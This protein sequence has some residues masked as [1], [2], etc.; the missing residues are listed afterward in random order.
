ML[1]D[2]IISYIPDFV[3][4]FFE[5]Y[6]YN[7]RISKNKELRVA[8]PPFVRFCFISCYISIFCAL[9]LESA[10]WSGGSW[11]LLLVVVLLITKLDWP[12]MVVK[13]KQPTQNCAKEILENENKFVELWR[14]N[15]GISKYQLRNNQLKKVR[16]RFPYSTTR[17]QVDIRCIYIIQWF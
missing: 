5:T 4:D 10:S 16:S 8:R 7:F 12:C 1:V 6:N 3:L 11:V 14:W 13:K 9:D 2:F 15:A 17:Q